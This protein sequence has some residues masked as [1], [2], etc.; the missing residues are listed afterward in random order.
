MN[1][2]DFIRYGV[3][4]YNNGWIVYVYTSIKRHGSACPRARAEY[5]HT[6]V[7][8]IYLHTLFFGVLPSMYM[9]AVIHEDQTDIFSYCSTLTCYSLLME[10]VFSAVIV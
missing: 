8:T 2:G 7:F 1:D 5:M 4:I 10:Y 3:L 9:C 6:Q